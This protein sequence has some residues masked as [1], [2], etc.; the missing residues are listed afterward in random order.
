M[1]RKYVKKQKYL[2]SLKESESSSLDEENIVEIYS[3][4][5]SEEYI[6]DVLRNIQ[7]T[8]AM[9]I[10][11]PVVA[12]ITYVR[13]WFVFHSNVGEFQCLIR[14]S[15]FIL[16]KGEKQ[17]NSRLHLDEI[18]QALKTIGVL[19]WWNRKT[20]LRNCFLFLSEFFKKL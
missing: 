4:E 1:S 9:V 3:G 19:E 12:N 16:K 13:P 2:K 17:C 18:T 7:C 11:K 20:V 5:A 14:K 8:L 10:R 6:D 15:D